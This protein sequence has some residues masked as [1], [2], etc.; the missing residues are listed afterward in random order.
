MFKARWTQISHFVLNSEK[1]IELHQ[2]K[3]VFG[4]SAVLLIPCSNE[5]ISRVAYAQLCKCSSLVGNPVSF[6]PLDVACRSPS[7][8]SEYMRRYC[9]GL[10]LAGD[11]EGYHF[12][13]L[14]NLSIRCMVE[15]EAEIISRATRRFAE[16]NDW[17]ELDSKLW[18][19]IAEWDGSHVGLAAAHC[20]ATLFIN[21]SEIPLQIANIQLI[22]GANLKIIPCAGYYSESRILLAGGSV[23]IF[24][25]GF[26][27][28]PVESGNVHAEVSTDYFS[29]T[30]SSD[31][32]CTHA[33]SRGGQKVSF[34]EK[35]CSQ[36]WSKY[37]VHIS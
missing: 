23:C 32:T 20:M 33:N 34:L 9:R 16:A 10:N 28:T 6:L 8:R 2:Y 25:W 4:Q 27:P 13:S 30:L 36:W 19:M 21:M 17:K 12:G 3:H 29:L 26:S 14:N 22:S 37:V 1:G 7:E 24:A 31:S 5:A 15:S 11:L 35:S 18:L